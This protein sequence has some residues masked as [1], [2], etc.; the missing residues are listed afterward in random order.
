[1]KAKC[2]VMPTTNI[3]KMVAD[4]IKVINIFFTLFVNILRK[5][6]RGKRAIYKLSIFAIIMV[7][8]HEGKNMSLFKA[9]KVYYEYFWQFLYTHGFIGAYMIF[10]LFTV[11]LVIFVQLFSLTEL[12]KAL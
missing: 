11:P 5:V 9:L 7:T 12:A 6:K 3:S 8:T 2:G 1:M 10:A 4:S